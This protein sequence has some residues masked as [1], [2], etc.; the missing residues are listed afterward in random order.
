MDGIGASDRPWSPQRAHLWDPVLPLELQVPRDSRAGIFPGIQRLQE[1][2]AVAEEVSEGLGVIEAFRVDVVPSPESSRSVVVI[3]LTASWAPW[4]VSS[5]EGLQ[6][7]HRGP[8]HG[9]VM[10]FRGPLHSRRCPCTSERVVLVL[11]LVFPER[12]RHASPW[13]CGS[14]TGAVGITTLGL[15]GL[16][17]R[18]GLSVCGLPPP[19]VLPFPPRVWRTPCAPRTSAGTEWGERRHSACSQRALA[20]A[21][22]SGCPPVS[23]REV[24][25]PSAVGGVDGR[26]RVHHEITDGV[27][28]VSRHSVKLVACGM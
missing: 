20:G 3:V 26:L 2:I 27:H 28:D 15:H 10:G 4:L 19:S 23:P 11:G 25:A 21:P 17:P 14:A 5:H 12:R 18:L 13:A 8:H 6:G 7:V 1:V 24:A 9:L 16:S 22:Q